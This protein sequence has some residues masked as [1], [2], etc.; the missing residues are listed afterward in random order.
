MLMRF[1]Q[2]PRATGGHRRVVGDHGI[3]TDWCTSQEAASRN[4][5][6]YSV[7]HRWE[8]L[9]DSI[10]SFREVPLIAIFYLGMAISALSGLIGFVLLLEKIFFRRILEGW[11]SVM[12]SVW[13]LGGDFDLLR[14]ANR[15]LHFKKSSSKPRAAHIRL[16]AGYTAS[17]TT[18][19][20]KPPPHLL[21]ADLPRAARN[22][23]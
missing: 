15:H 14:R 20:S 8:I 17:S 21:D 22:S 3:Q 7:W 11:V 1:R 23:R 19:V 2:A 4:A 5:P 6:T 12:L 10:T 18:A 13:F 9:I 16:F